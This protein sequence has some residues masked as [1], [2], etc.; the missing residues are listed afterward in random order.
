MTNVKHLFFDLDHTLWD[1]ETNSELTFKQIF[2]EQ[3][4]AIGFSEFFKIYSP[5]NM[6]YW[7]SYRDN[8][9]SKEELRYKRLRETF[10][11]LDFE[12]SDELINII[13]KDYIDYLPN[14]S[15][16]LEGAIEVL[17]YLKSKYVL[18]IIT[19]G[20]EEVQRQKLEKSEI[21][22]YFDVI[23]TSECVGV[24]KPNPKVFEYAMEKAKA[25]ANESV[26]IGDSFEADVL[27]AMQ[28]GMKAIHL[29]EGKNDSTEFIAVKSL[30]EIKQYL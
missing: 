13:A 4:I 18:H 7:R 2:K 25:G 1:F 24:K 6:K 22:H 17:E 10:D 23:V 20:F 28:V 9:I 16:L 21:S 8:N 15:N 12:I 26:M 11:N 3:N 5:I 29:V 27:G 19:N 14:Y 30:H